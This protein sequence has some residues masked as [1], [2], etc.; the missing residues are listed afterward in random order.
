MV[1]SRNLWP[2]PTYVLTRELTELTDN[3]IGQENSNSHTGTDRH[4]NQ[5]IYIYIYQNF[6]D[7]HVSSLPMILILELQ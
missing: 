7:S 4:K 2:S 1:M 3:L 5:N 6:G